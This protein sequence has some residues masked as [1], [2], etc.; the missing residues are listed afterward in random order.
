YEKFIRLPDEDN[1]TYALKLSEFVK[2]ITVL[3][4]VKKHSALSLAK[5]PDSEKEKLFSLQKTIGYYSRLLSYDDNDELSDEAKDEYGKKLFNARMK[6][7]EL[8]RALAEKN[9]AY[10]ET[11]KIDVDISVSEIRDSLL[12]EDQSAVE[13]F[14][15]G[16]ELYSF[17]VAPDTFAVVKQILPA[18]F[19]PEIER[20]IKSV[21]ND[22]YAEFIKSSQ[23]VYGVVFAGADSLIS[24]PRL[25]IINDGV[26]G[27]IPY[28]ILLYKEPIE[29]AGYKNL[30][31]LIKKYSIG[32]AYSFNLLRSSADFDDAVS[33]FLGIAPFSKKN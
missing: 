26:L 21:E 23:S 17:V 6:Y 8:N 4:N 20:L 7:D 25:L 12:D 13:Y 19:E 27:Y 1:F 33:N 14:M 31:Y 30:P 24:T 29:N 10:K 22:N 32:Y 18:D 11:T 9:P 3:E 5:I 16:K 15:S 2:A 28:D